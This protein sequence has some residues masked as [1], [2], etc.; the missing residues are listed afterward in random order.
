MEGGFFSSG[1]GG[2]SQLRRGVL[3]IWGWGFF[4]AKVGGG[5]FYTV[6]GGGLQYISNIT[7]PFYTRLSATRSLIVSR[8]I[9]CEAGNTVN[10]R[11]WES[12]DHGLMIDQT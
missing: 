5:G 4:S 6:G 2:S 9:F 1:G 12:K 11:P 8:N 3:L 10:W 7:K